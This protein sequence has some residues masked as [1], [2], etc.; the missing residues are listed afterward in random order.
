MRKD[1]I[2]DR[3]GE[4]DILQRAA[5]LDIGGRLLR[6]A[7][8]RADHQKYIIGTLRGGPV[9]QV[10]V[11]PDRDGAVISD[12]RTPALE[13]AEKVFRNQRPVYLLLEMLQ[14][15][16]VAGEKHVFGAA[17][18][19]DFVIQLLRGRHHKDVG[20]LHEVIMP[21]HGRFRNWYSRNLF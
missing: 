7:V 16:T 13:N 5:A 11:E 4:D 8:L 9:N 17:R 20:V 19:H 18:R 15:H 1:L 14:I 6:V 10:I 21:L 2:V 3:S 12:D